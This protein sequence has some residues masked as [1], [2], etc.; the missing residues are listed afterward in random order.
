M[1]CIACSLLSQTH[2]TGILHMDVVVTGGKVNVG[3]DSKQR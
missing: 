2:D 3:H 1:S